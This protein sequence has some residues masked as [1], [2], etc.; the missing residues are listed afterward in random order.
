[1]IIFLTDGDV[2]LI[3]SINF[4][5]TIESLVTRASDPSNG[6]QPPAKPHYN[7][8]EQA[9][10][11]RFPQEFTP[12]S[13]SNAFP[14]DSIRSWFNRELQHAGLPS[15]KPSSKRWAYVKYKFGLDGRRQ[16]WKLKSHLRTISSPLLSNC[17]NPQ[18]D[19]SPIT[20]F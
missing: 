19:Y 20:N 10:L 2:S 13:V 3:L 9:L 12:V 7:Q 1:M 16:G 18:Q 4:I 11:R 8:V 17:S 14:A 5:E 6:R 15:W